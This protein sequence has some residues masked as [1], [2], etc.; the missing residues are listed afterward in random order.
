MAGV[1]DLKHQV[2]GTNEVGRGCE[3]C[4]HIGYIREESIDNNEQNLIHCCG[5]F[6][7]CGGV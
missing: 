4:Y 6:R 2:K 7:Y 5:L 1:C 3:F